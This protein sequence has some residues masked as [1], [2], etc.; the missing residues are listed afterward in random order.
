MG[1]IAYRRHRRAEKAAYLE[2]LKDRITR[3]ELDAAWADRPD[4]VLQALMLMENRRR[5]AD[6]MLLAQLGVN[7]G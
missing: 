2:R 7:F 4:A 5:V 6:V 3:A 1:P